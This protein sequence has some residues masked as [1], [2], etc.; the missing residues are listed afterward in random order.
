MFTTFNNIID[1]KPRSA[2]TSYHG[3][4]PSTEEPLWDAPVATE[5][6]VEDAV[7]AARRA[8]ASW[9]DVLFE[10][11]C[12]LV[13][14]YAEAFL[15]HEGEM[16]QLLQ[17]ETGKP[18]DVA[19]REIHSSYEGLMAATQWTL[20]VERLEDEKKTATLRYT[21]LGVVGAICPWNYPL[22]LY[23]ACLSGRELYHCQAL[24]WSAYP[25]SEEKRVSL[26]LASPYTPYSTLKAVE[27]GASIFPPGVLQVLG[28]DDKLGPLLVSHPQIQMISFTGSIPTGKK[29]M[30]I[31]VASKRIYIHRSIYEPFLAEMVSFT[32]GLKVGNPLVADV[33]IGPIQNAMQYA[34][35]QS[36]FADCKEKGYKF[37]TGNGAA[38]HRTLE[39]ESAHRKGYFVTPTIIENPPSN[40][41]LVTEEP[42]GPIIPVQPWSEETDVIART[43]DTH[44]GLGACIWSRDLEMAERIAVQLEVGSVYINSPLRP[45]WRVYFSG[46]KES[47]VGGE[48]GLQGLLAYCKAQAVHAYR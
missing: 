23:R 43:N 22:V 37:A 27:I 13:K 42:F 35:V 39:G 25:Q 14:R 7:S 6:D 24:V 30:E 32:E 41:K 26:T 4:D 12:D 47:G 18:K 31:C 16:M 33:D 3:I 15:S 40:S 36:F 46:H 48:R 29:I 28:G 34:K 38:E 44:M 20:P 9:S 2:E 8:F 1:G 19:F 45:D 11:R 10:K 5:A 21:P 17:R